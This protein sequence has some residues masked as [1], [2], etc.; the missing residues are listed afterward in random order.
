HESAHLDHKHWIDLI[1]I[2][3][4][5]T[6]LWYWPTIWLLR[7]DLTEIHEYQADAE[8]L[9]SGI[10]A[11]NYQ[12]MLLKKAAGPRYHS[13]ACSLNN[14]SNI[15]KRIKM[16]LRKKSRPAVRL[17][18]AWAVPAVALGIGVLCSPL[19]SSALD[20]VSE[21]KVTNF[22]ASSQTPAADTV[23]IVSETCTSSE[24]RD[25]KNISVINNQEA[26]KTTVL[27]IDGKRRPF[28]EMKSLDTDNVEVNVFKGSSA[29]TYLS[30]EEIKAGKDTVIMIQTKSDDKQNTVVND[31]DSVFSGSVTVNGENKPYQVRIRKRSADDDQEAGKTNVVIIDGNRKSYQEMKNLDSDKIESITGFTGSSAETYL[32]LE[33][34][35]AG[36]N[37]VVVVQTKSDNSDNSVVLNDSRDEQSTVVIIDGKR[38]SY[39]DMKRLNSNNIKSITVFDGSS[40]EKYLSEE[41]IKA[42]KNTVIVFESKS[43]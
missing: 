5:A 19:I 42:G 8:V 25:R 23:D 33:D 17:R 36:K 4:A 20:T 40:A 37:T 2:E 18:A 31:Q 30:E 21:A 26:E 15:S 14:H 13:I 27:I 35:K 43:K 34:L 39:R 41:D 9:S 3:L 10:D 32:A 12:I 1:V 24:V 28:N 6:F 16:M 22:F 29:K 7:R 11:R 38:K